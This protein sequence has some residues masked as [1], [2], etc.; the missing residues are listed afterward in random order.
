MAD[1]RLERVRRNP[2]SVRPDELDAVFR[3]AGYSARQRGSHKIYS[4]G[5]ATL[6]VPQRKPH[7]LESYVRAALALLDAEGDN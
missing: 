6:S 2:K 5:E 4:K 7:L 1:K 3:A